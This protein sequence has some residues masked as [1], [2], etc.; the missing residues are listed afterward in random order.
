MHAKLL[1][2]SI[3]SKKLSNEILLYGSCIRE[4][5]PELL[6]KF[7]GV[8]LRKQERGSFAPTSLLR[9]Q[10][11]EASALTTLLHACLS[12]TDM[13]AVAWKISMIVKENNTRKI[14]VLTLDGSPHCI[15][16]HYALEDV[17][18]FFRKLKV[19]HYVIEKG[20]IFEVSSAAVKASRHL[21]KVG[22]C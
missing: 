2:T 22:Q 8:H 6:K 9:Q 16:M 11:R 18:K 14:S 20:R 5:Y 12:E 1:S 15:Q 21:S 13:H 17:K 4:E 10:E 19:K 3:T 7:S